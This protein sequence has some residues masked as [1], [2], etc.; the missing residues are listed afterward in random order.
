MTRFVWTAGF[1]AMRKG[2]SYEVRMAA[3][4]AAVILHRGGKVSWVVAKPGAETG[5]TGD[6][7]LTLYVDSPVEF[8][9]IRDDHP[10]DCTCGCGGQPVVTQLLPE[11][12]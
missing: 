1:A 4:L 2:A 10:A 5:S 3:A 8:W 7:G 11:E 12:Y 6:E 9:S